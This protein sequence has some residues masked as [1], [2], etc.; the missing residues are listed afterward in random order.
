M[1]VILDESV[2]VQPDII[3]ISKDRPDIISNRGV[4]GAPDLLIEILSP[5]TAKY[6]KISKMQLYARY[7]VQWYWIVDPDEKKLEE[8]RCECAAYVL[9]DVYSGNDRFAP[10]IFPELMIDLSE[11]WA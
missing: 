11:I 2:I 6:D 4:D 7:G 3:F 1:D 10:G 9:R 8:Y 5:A